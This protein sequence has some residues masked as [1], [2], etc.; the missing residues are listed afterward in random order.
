MGIFKG[1]TKNKLDWLTWIIELPFFAFF[2]SVLYRY[3]PESIVLSYGTL[4]NWSG[5]SLLI[6]QSIQI[7]RLIMYMSHRMVQKMEENTDLEIPIKTFLISISIT[8]YIISGIMVYFMYHHPAMTVNFSS[9]V[10]IICCALIVLAV[11]VI[12]FV[13]IGIISDIALISLFVIFIVRNV[14]LET[15]IQNATRF[16]ES[17]YNMNYFLG[18]FSQSVTVGGTTM[19]F[20]QFFTIDF[21]ISSLLA[22]STLISLPL[23]SLEVKD[24]FAAEPEVTEAELETAYE[25][26]L[27]GVALVML[28]THVLLTSSGNIV[29]SG[30]IWRIVQSFLTIG[31]Y[32]F[33]LYQVHQSTDEFGHFK[34][35]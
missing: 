26:N 10:A 6:F 28:Y 14:I 19:N 30:P 7:V 25:K 23:I 8:A 4:L 5:P 13:Q 18:F 22:I 17:S 1:L 3:I 35:D 34:Y 31:F 12:F 24:D 33:R 32:C 16:F 29:P 27:L 20:G 15:P 9:Y 11:A 2:C 21:V